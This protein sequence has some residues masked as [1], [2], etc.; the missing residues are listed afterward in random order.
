M[1]LTSPP[2]AQGLAVIERP[3]AVKKEGAM[4][5]FQ[6]DTREVLSVQ[7]RGSTFRGQQCG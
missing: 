5:S 2:T 3:W 7:G 1:G 4:Q 6:M